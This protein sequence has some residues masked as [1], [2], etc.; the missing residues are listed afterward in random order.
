MKGDDVGVVDVS[1]EEN[2]GEEAVLELLAH[3]F[4]DDL[5][6]GHLRP[7]NPVPPQPHLRE[8]PRPDPPPDHVLPNHPT[9]SSSA[10][11]ARHRPFFFFFAFSF[12]IKEEGEEPSTRQRGRTKQKNEDIRVFLPLLRFR[13]QL[14]KRPSGGREN[15][16]R[17]RNRNRILNKG[18]EASDTTSPSELRKVKVT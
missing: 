9:S 12:L 13:N 2:L 7:P 4:H 11:R 15:Y 5:L 3:A 10:A 18:S 17:G 16:G 6:H 8:C 1:K 14:E